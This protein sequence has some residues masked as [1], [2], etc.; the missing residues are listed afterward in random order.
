MKDKISS[1]AAVTEA[2]LTPFIPQISAWALSVGTAIGWGSMFVTSNTYLMQA[3]PMGTIIGLIAGALVMIVIARNYHYMMNCF[4]DAGGAYTYAKETFGYDHGFVAAWFLSLTYISIFWANVTAL[5]LFSRYFFGEFFRHG[6]LYTLF[7]S[8]DVYLG[9]AILSMSAIVIFCV[10][11]ASY[12]KFSIRLLTVTVIIFTL[13]IIVCILGCVPQMASF[14]KTFSPGY[15]PEKSE[16]S[17]IIR[18]ASISPWAFIGFENISHVTEEISFPRSRVFKILTASIVASTALYI[19]ITLL[20]ITAYPSE[21]GSWLNYI[22]AHGS[23]SGLRGLPPFYAADYYL[24]DT[25]VR[26]LMLS[27]LCIIVSSLI[28]NL[29]ALSR[30]MY[31]L[32]KDSVLPVQL[33]ELN[34]Q[35]VPAKAITVIAVISLFIPFLGRTAIG[36]IVDVTTIGATIVYAFVS[37]TAYKLA[38]R[39][40]DTVEKRFGMAGTVLMVIFLALLL[41]PAIFGSGDL[42]PETYFLFT[43]WAILGFL[44]FRTIL[45]RDISRRF[46]RSVIV[47]IALLGM[48]MFTTLV[49]MGESSMSAS[50]QTVSEIR[51]TY[52]TRIVDDARM[53]ELAKD[54][55]A[56]PEKLEITINDRTVDVAAE[57][58][59]LEKDLADMRNANTRRVVIVFT[60]F[61]MAIGI[62]LNNYSLVIRRAEEKEHELGVVREKANTDSLTGVKNK[63]TYDEYELS[64]NKHINEGI[65]DEFSVVVCDI[66]GLKHVNDTYGHKAGDDLIRAASDMICHIFK[67]SP[68]FRIGGDEFVVILTGRDRVERAAL[69]HEIG[70]RSEENLKE[71]KVVVAAGMSDFIPDYDETI[72][73]VFERADL[74]M[75]E[76]KEELKAM[77]AISR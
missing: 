15:V 43:V 22:R 74:M 11:T 61:L 33:A 19:F 16:I 30:L 52:V 20:S 36:W 32:A 26:I 72:K 41:L 17:Q 2:R 10:M 70:R 49:W 24:G 27:L 53:L 73:P 39:R 9:E 3:G 68:V 59:L 25:G 37:A 69:M 65:A 28:G 67:H 6:Y 64:I 60:L 62:L 76:R 18:I 50:E 46:G 34:R 48:I 38:S 31:A 12:K 5:P 35:D 66:N 47:W 14:N 56:D 1:D 4:P 71:D 77:G 55:Q 23:L 51:D 29:M 44:F 58:A 21:Y 13:G 63:R 54:P 7:G 57:D 75:Y 45:R 40:G 42:A 8:Y